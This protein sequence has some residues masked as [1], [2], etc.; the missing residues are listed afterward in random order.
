MLILYAPD[1]V[2]RFNLTVQEVSSTT[3]PYMPWSPVHE[4]HFAIAFD[5][6]SKNPLFGQGPQLFRTLSV[7]ELSENK[8][9]VTALEYNPSKFLAAEKKGPPRSPSLPIPPQADMSLPEAPDGLLL[10]DLTV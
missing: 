6:F 8:Y 10:F 4:S 7:K 2:E 1:S 3:I 5:M 9:E